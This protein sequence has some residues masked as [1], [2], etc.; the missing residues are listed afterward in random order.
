MEE[1]FVKKALAKIE[2][3]ASEQLKDQ[4]LTDVSG[5]NY[6]N[7]SGRLSHLET[8]TIVQTDKG[9]EPGQ[10]NNEQMYPEQ[11][12]NDAPPYVG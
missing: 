12:S 4:Q 1:Q 6:T 7:A 11:I 9:E 10:T 8:R 2:S 5:G 3:V